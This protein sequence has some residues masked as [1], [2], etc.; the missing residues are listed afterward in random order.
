MFRF[1]MTAARIAIALFPVLAGVAQAGTVWYVNDTATGAGT[2][3]SWADAFTDLQDALDQAVSGD[4]IWVA[5]GIYRPSQRVNAD[6]PR[7]ATFHLVNGVAVYGGFTGVETQ[8]DQ[9]DWLSVTS[10]LSG[11]LAGDDEPGFVNYDENSYHVVMVQFVA[12]TVALDGLT[13]SGG[14]ANAEDHEEYVDKRGGGAFLYEAV[15]D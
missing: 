15:K 5:R 10:M 7:S 9:R 6:D 11:D 4:E 13:I 3:T 2:G 1:E 14:N 8:R 12:D